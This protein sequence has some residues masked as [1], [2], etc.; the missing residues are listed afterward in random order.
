MELVG[1]PDVV[2]WQFGPK[3]GGFGPW[4][5]SHRLRT[6]VSFKSPVSIPRELSPGPKNG[7][8][9]LS[10]KT[11]YLVPGTRSLVPG[12]WYQVPGTGYL[13]PGTRCQVLSWEV[14]AYG[15][16]APPPTPPNGASGAL[17]GLR[18]PKPP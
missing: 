10:D 2:E 7:Q 6:A 11:R 3:V 17:G 14:P 18:P 5:W 9:F 1:S 8:V 12:T 15:W 13:V 4:E 16:G